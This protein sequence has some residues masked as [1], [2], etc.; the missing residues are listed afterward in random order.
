M[1][2]LEAAKK[3]MRDIIRNRVL[4]RKRQK[5]IENTNKLKTKEKNT[6]TKATA[7][8]ATATKRMTKYR[9]DKDKLELVRNEHLTSNPQEGSEYFRR[10]GKYYDVVTLEPIAWTNPNGEIILHPKKKST[11]KSTLKRRK[12]L[13]QLAK[14]IKPTK[15]KPVYRGNMDDLELVRDEHISHNPGGYEYFR[16]DGKYYDVITLELVGRTKPDR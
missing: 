11:L 13:N 14:A 4:G 15:P 7:T 16:K 6:S 1:S 9:G 10:D 2:Q 8:K 5:E 3:N 12:E